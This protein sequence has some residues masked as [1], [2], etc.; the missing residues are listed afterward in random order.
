MSISSLFLTPRSTTI[1]FGAMDFK[2]VADGLEF[3][4]GLVFVTLDFKAARPLG[5]SGG[6]AA[7]SIF[8]GV[9]R[10]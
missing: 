10:G 4:V 1:S 6:G 8:L 2:V 3:G 9:R 5:V 7:F